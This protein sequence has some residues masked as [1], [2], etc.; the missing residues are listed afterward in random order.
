MAELQVSPH[1]I[2]LI[3]NHASARKGTVTSAV[4]IQYSYDKEKREGLEAWG[5]LLEEIAYV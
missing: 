4:Y 3:L 1:T 5:R 2:S